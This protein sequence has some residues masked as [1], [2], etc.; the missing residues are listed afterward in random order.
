MVSLI[1]TAVNRRSHRTAGAAMG[2]EIVAYKDLR[3]LHSVERRAL[4]QIVRHDPEIE[5]VGH[6]VILTDPADKGCIFPGGVDGHRVDI[7]LRF[8]RYDNS[9]RFA[10]YGFDIR[11]G[12][13]LFRLDVY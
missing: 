1:F 7:I 9:R 3:N 2:S 8:V 5:T 6:G 10:Q 11:G 13:L 12:K 4:A